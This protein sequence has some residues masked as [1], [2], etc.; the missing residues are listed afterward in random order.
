MAHTTYSV[1]VET[2]EGFQVYYLQQ[3]GKAIAE[4]VPALGNNCYAFKVA[5]GDT[6]LNL[7]DAPPDL[8]TL[9]E[10]PTAYGNPILF[11]SPTESETARGNLR[12]KPIS[13]TRHRS[14]LQRS[15]AY[16]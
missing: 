10:R 7:I 4:I 9:E 13:S 6:W 15:T 1:M 12:G 3:D 5:D 14:P 8:A 2:V 16:C 11:L